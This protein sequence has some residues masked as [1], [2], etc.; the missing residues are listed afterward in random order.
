MQLAKSYTAKKEYSFFYAKVVDE[1]EF[2]ELLQKENP[3]KD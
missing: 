2:I 3:D 1:C